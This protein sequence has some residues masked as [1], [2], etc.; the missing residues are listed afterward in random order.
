MLSDTHICTNL[1]HRMPSTIIT[2]HKREGTSKCK[3]LQIRKW[4]I[5]M[6]QTEGGQDRDE[7]Y[8]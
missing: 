5:G 7:L 1:I 8:A 2:E 6:A 4:N 3:T